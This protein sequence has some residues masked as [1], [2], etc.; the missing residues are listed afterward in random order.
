MP[1]QSDDNM[2]PLNTTRT[3]HTDVW[4]GVYTTQLKNGLPLAER[5]TISG[6]NRTTH[7]TITPGYR[8]RSREGE[9]IMNDFHSILTD[10]QDE[11]A[12]VMR[13]YTNGDD[14]V[15][16][17][18]S[19]AYRFH[20]CNEPAVDVDSLVGEAVT[21]AHANITDVEAQLNVTL[22]EA[23]KTQAAL[24][25]TFRSAV[26]LMKEGAAV[27]RSFVKGF[28]SPR[29]AAKRWLH[30]RYGL[31]PIM[32][33]MQGYISAA[34][35]IGARRYTTAFGFSEDSPAPVT[36]K[37][38]YGGPEFDYTIV[39]TKTLHVSVRAGVVIEVRGDGT[40]ELGDLFGLTTPFST[41]WELVPYSFVIDWFFNTSKYIAA[42]SPKYTSAVKGSFA[43]VRRQSRDSI[44]IP[45]YEAKKGG[46]DIELGCSYNQSVTDVTRYAN[47]SLPAVP[48]LNVRLSTAKVTDILALALG[49]GLGKHSKV[50]KK[51]D[52]MSRKT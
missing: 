27:R 46:E 44:V 25:S 26:I 1:I 5:P 3:R 15:G 21:N 33:E 16:F 14:Y 41:A 42:W 7:D 39:R 32:Y 8:A 24:A 43:T 38:D 17:I 37:G 48:S 2:R 9:V 19:S 30:V 28:I 23:K 10:T 36:S 47:P 12:K 20:S 51:L 31:R 52:F 40:H 4:T 45:R 50:L 22:A 6:R 34:Q 49:L 29:T 13:Q 18:P 11:P 35:K